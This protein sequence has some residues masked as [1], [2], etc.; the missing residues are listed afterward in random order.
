MNGSPCGKALE[1]LIHL[2]R[3]CAKIHCMNLGMTLGEYV[4]HIPCFHYVR[5]I[6]LG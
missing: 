4:S 1:T 5:A 2:A 3:T 6:L